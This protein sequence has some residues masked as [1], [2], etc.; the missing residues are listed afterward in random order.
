MGGARSRGGDY[1][2]GYG[3]RLHLSARRLKRCST[4]R[5]LIDHTWSRATGRLGKSKD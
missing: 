5:R 4:R 1:R 2:P 3:S